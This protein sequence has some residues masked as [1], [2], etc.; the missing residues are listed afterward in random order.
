[1]KKDLLYFLLAL[2]LCALIFMGDLLVV[3]GYVEWLL[4]ILPLLLIYRA[5]RTDLTLIVLGIIAVL[6]GIGFLLSPDPGIPPVIS[7][8]DRIEGFIV[9][10]AY[11]LT[12]I[13]LI[14]TQKVYFEAKN[15]AEKK[16]EEI[17]TMNKELEAFSYSVSHDLRNPLYTVG[18]FIKL[19]QEDYKDQLDEQ[20]REYLRLVEKGIHKMHHLIDDLLSLSK[21]SRQEVHREAFNLSLMALSILKE[22][23]HGQPVRSVSWQV[24]PDLNV[25]ADPR[26]M[27]IALSNLIGNAWKY[28]AKTVNAK[29]EFSAKKQDGRTVF[30]VRDNGAGFDSNRA[31][32]LFTPFRRFHSEKEF[33]GTGIGLTIVERIIRRHGGKIWVESQVGKGATFYFTIN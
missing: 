13:T 5:R 17:T 22:L 7:L 23:A 20:G 21:V 12:I 29:V 26:L 9:F 4:Y 14:R 32:S 31:D 28:T 16:S 6:L 8:I 30:Y 1:M 33:S 15:S 27:S 2:V 11:T 25:Y 18:S 24:Q 3:R 10:A 19:L